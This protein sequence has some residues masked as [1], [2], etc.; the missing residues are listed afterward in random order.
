M[1]GSFAIP[2]W[3]LGVAEIISIFA[4]R[5][6]HYKF[7]KESPIMRRV[8]AIINK[9]APIVLLVIIVLDLIWTPYIMYLEN[10]DRTGDILITQQSKINNLQK[11][12]SAITK[13]N[14]V[15]LPIKDQIVNAHD[16]ASLGLTATPNF[17][18]AYSSII[19]YEVHNPDPENRIFEIVRFKV[20]PSGFKFSYI[21][22]VKLP[23]YITI[24]DEYSGTNNVVVV[25]NGCP[26]LDTKVIDFPV[27]NMDT[28]PSIRGTEKLSL[29]I[30][31][32]RVLP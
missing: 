27:Y 7:K 20:S 19:P 6:I 18:P 9:W 24:L 8:M 21:D 11:Q 25:I 3:I 4:P 12:I 14:F 29:E 2:L 23:D 28:N 10:Q 16:S 26:P 15:S 17:K 32:N 31:D 13:L 22:P 1:D 5:F 30:L